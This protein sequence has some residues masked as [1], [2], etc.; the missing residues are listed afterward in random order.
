MLEMYSTTFLTFPGMTHYRTPLVAY[1]LQKKKSP[2]KSRTRMNVIKCR[3]MMKSGRNLLNSVEFTQ[4]GE[5][6][7]GINQKM[8]SFSCT[9]RRKT[10]STCHFLIK[11]RII[12][13]ESRIIYDAIVQQLYH[14]FHSLVFCFGTYGFSVE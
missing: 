4:F 5:S 10:V 14:N 3:F 8:H 6:H 13:S 7:I 9:L 12:S 1:R 2:L 11:P